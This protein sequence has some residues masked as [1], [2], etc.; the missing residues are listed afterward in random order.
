IKTYTP[1]LH[2]ALP[3]YVNR[4]G[5]VSL[6]FLL[7]L[8]KESLVHSSLHDNVLHKTSV[9]SSRGERDA[10]KVQLGTFQTSY[11]FL[12]TSN[13]FDTRRSEEH[14]SELQSRENL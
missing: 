14:T 13:P 7:Q 2:D 8:L 4:K 9:T 12:E 11:Q 3:I 6:N 1:S 10:R 5:L